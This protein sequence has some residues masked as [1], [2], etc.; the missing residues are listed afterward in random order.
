[1]NIKEDFSSNIYFQLGLIESS[2]KAM[3]DGFERI[4]SAQNKSESE[5]D[6]A[7]ISMRLAFAQSRSM[8]DSVRCREKNVGLRC[9]ERLGHGPRCSARSGNN[10]ITWDNT[11]TEITETR[12]R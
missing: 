7:M 9:E 10:G 5:K 2:L 4:E 11:I 3:C 12:T 1:M 8:L 6:I